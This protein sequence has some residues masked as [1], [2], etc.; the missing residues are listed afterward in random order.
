MSIEVNAATAFVGV[1][2]ANNVRALAEQIKT[3][4]L[5]WD[6]TL[7]ALV[8]DGGLVVA[9]VVPVR[10]VEYP[11]P[12]WTTT[13]DVG[14]EGDGNGNDRLELRARHETLGTFRAGYTWAR[15]MK[16]GVKKRWVAALR[17]GDYTQG[18]GALRRGDG[19]CCLGVLCDVYRIEKGEE[20]VRDGDEIWLFGGR[21]VDLPLEV[22]TWAG[23][24][25]VLPI[26][27]IDTH[28]LAELN[29]D[30]ASFAEIADLIEANA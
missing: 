26:P 28:N 7:E 14:V 15:P 13:W 6:A 10:T 17:S 30:E 5:H 19:F 9:P 12:G 1:S 25:P 20:W 4:H 18:K 24:D 3:Q 23:L 16:A 11:L 29:D 2:V 21:A 8:D 27:V 22:L